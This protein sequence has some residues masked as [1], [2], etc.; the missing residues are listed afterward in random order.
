MIEEAT[1]ETMRQQYLSGLRQQR[2]NVHFFSR[3]ETLHKSNKNTSL[4]LL[5]ALYLNYQ[6]QNPRTWKSICLKCNTARSLAAPL[7]CCY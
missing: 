1:S 3:N 2:Q 7:S 6:P 4:G 5:A